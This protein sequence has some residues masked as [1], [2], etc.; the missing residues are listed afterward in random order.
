[1]TATTSVDQKPIGLIKTAVACGLKVLKFGILVALILATLGYVAEKQEPI[2]RA[3]TEAW[4]VLMFALSFG[5]QLWGAVA[6]GVFGG[7]VVAWALCVGAKLPDDYE[8]NA[9]LVLIGVG[10]VGAALW[11]LSTRALSGTFET[12]GALTIYQQIAVVVLKVPYV[13]GPIAIFS[14]GLASLPNQ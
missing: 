6:T 13:A 5:G 11:F 14:V 2:G 7:A 8:G 10:M 1:M 9:I 3:C 4:D 12:F